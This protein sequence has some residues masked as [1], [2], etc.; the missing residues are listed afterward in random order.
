MRSSDTSSR[1]LPTVAAMAALLM[2]SASASAQRM[3]APPLPPGSD[4]I[5]I[6]PGESP[7]EKARAVRAHKH[8]QLHKKSQAG[9]TPQAAKDTGT[10]GAA[11]TADESK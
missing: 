5:R 7:V 6:M 3:P 1:L 2:F 11:G 8:V 4:M 10:S 9:E